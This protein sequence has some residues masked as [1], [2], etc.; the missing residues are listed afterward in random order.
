MTRRIAGIAIVACAAFVVAAPVKA[1]YEVEEGVLQFAVQQDEVPAPP[2]FQPPPGPTNQGTSPSDRQLDSTL[3]AQDTVVRSAAAR[4]RLARTPE[5]F[6]DFF[7][8]TIILPIDDPTLI[9]SSAGPGGGITKISDSN[10]A[11]I[12]CRTYILYNHFHNAIESELDLG[13]PLSERIKDHI[14]RFTIGL[15]RPLGESPWSFEFRVPIFVDLDVE[16]G[17]ISS[18]DAGN[19]G[20]IAG[21]LKRELYS[22][23]VAVISAGFGVSLP[24]GEDINAAGDNESLV[25][26]NEAV[27]ILPFLA[28]Q[29]EWDRWFF[30]GFLQVDVDVNGNTVEAERTFFDSGVLNDQTLLFVDLGLGRWFYRNDYAPYLQ[31]VAGLFEVHYE[32]SLQDAD[33]L[34][35]DIGPFPGPATV[36]NIIN[37]FDVIHLTGAL[38]F[39]I[40]ERSSLRIG[41]SAP[42]T[43]GDNRFF[44]AEIAAQFI[45]RCHHQ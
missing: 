25:I 8:P 34:V 13:G 41:A 23:D 6:G 10:K 40:G 37:R 1:Q 7:G 38:Q 27:H 14:D 17:G 4:R 26:R 18:Y 9:Q 28:V 42:V 31:G 19:L 5:M 43:S 21:I 11:A 29:R 30:H 20:N 35:L 15:E 22:T 12:G 3:A 33:I 45:I 24:T 16:F 44:D 39:D 2:G 36:G 32:T